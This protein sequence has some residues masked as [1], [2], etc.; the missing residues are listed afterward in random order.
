MPAFKLKTEV[1]RAW[2]KGQ[3]QMCNTNNA[4]KPSSKVKITYRNTN[5][6]WKTK[7]WMGLDQAA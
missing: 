3:G 2:K 7:K 1:I 5:N 4:Q 6:A